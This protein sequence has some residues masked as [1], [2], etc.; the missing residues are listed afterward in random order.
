MWANTRSENPESFGR[1]GWWWGRRTPEVQHRYKA[2]HACVQVDLA[3]PC[4]VSV[5]LLF[6]CE[7]HART[8]RYDTDVCARASSVVK[9]PYINHPSMSHARVQTDSTVV[10]KSLC[11]YAHA[12][13]ISR[14]C[15]MQRS[16][17]II[18]MYAVWVSGS[19]QKVCH[20]DGRLWTSCLLY[21]TCSASVFGQHDRFKTCTG[22]SM[23]C[24][25]FSYD[26]YW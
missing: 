11:Y 23:E 3:A 7:Q 16:A 9:N 13:H 24:L 19:V 26:T 8:H 17:D 4:D 2:F 1:V 21:T 15:S 5:F 6:I 12:S 10:L 18:P 20:E 14:A 22:S 25:C